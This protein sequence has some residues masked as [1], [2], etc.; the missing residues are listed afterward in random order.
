MSALDKNHDCNSNR[1]I[2]YAAGIDVT[3]PLR[4]LHMRLEE[5]LF[6]FE[7]RKLGTERHYQNAEIH[8]CREHACV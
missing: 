3:A 1:T 6:I 2:H 7:H 5:T 4:Y 8:D